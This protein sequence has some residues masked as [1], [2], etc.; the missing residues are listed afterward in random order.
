MRIFRWLVRVCSLVF[1][2]F[3]AASLSGESW[4]VMLSTPDKIGLIVWA[5]IL[6]GMVL[7]WRSE[8]GGGFIIITGF[9][10]QVA[11]HPDVLTIWTMWVAP[12]IGGLFVISWAMSEGHWSR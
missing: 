9:I 4:P 10:I 1:L 5:L 8:G 7:A 6:C 11:L 3:Q 12:A 2:A